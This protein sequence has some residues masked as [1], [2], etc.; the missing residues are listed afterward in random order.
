MSSNKLCNFRTELLLLAAG[1]LVIS[2]TTATVAIR[3]IDVAIIRFVTIPPFLPLAL[4]AMPGESFVRALMSAAACGSSGS[5]SQDT[6]SKSSSALAKKFFTS[7]LLRMS[8]VIVQLISGDNCTVTVV[9]RLF[10]MH[11]LLLE[12][13]D[14]A[15]TASLSK[16]RKNVAVCSVTETL[17]LNDVRLRN[18][19]VYIGRNQ[20]FSAIGDR[21]STKQH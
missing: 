19:N 5:A 20:Y 6:V 4:L 14:N 13:R 16:L 18:S 21:G 11:I 9:L 1:C 10:M 17:I 3:R 12:K 2:T 8:F 7:L 15:T